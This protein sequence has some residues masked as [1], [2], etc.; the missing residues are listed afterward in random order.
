MNEQAK[1]ATELFLGGL[2]CSQAVLGA[3]C[4][5][6]ELDASLANRI[7]FGLNSGCRCAD[8]CGAVSG[9]LLVVGLKYG[10]NRS[11]GN[12][13]IEEYIRIFKEKYGSI[14]CRDLLGCDISTPDGNEQAIAKNLYKTRCVEIVA[15]S[16]EILAGLD[17]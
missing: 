12:K 15:S 13:S 3:F 6:Y 4:E 11:I 8:V 17:F 14:I 7:S 10:D 2:Y 5:K 16:A 9:A 1:K